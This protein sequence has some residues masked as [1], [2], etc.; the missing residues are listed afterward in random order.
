MSLH[1]STVARFLDRSFGGWYH[2][3]FGKWLIQQLVTVGQIEHQNFDTQYIVGW[4]L[5]W[6]KWLRYK[7][8][9]FTTWTSAWRNVMISSRPCSFM[10]GR[11]LAAKTRKHQDNRSLRSPVPGIAT[12]RDT[13]LFHDLVP[14]EDFRKLHCLVS[15]EQTNKWF[16]MIQCNIRSIKH[17]KL[18][19][20]SAGT[21]YSL[22]AFLLATL[23]V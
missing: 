18:V 21:I 6:K 17:S 15:A 4:Y 23:A 12:A 13:W 5:D 19:Q 8:S 3:I 2:W 1:L 16:F 11:I 14:R 10:P 7:V 20:H 9:S 22:F